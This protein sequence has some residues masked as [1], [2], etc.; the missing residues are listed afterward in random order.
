MWEIGLRFIFACSPGQIDDALEF[1]AHPSIL[2]RPCLGD[3]LSSFLKL[4]GRSLTMSTKSG[5]LLT[6]YPPTPSWHRFYDD[7]RKMITKLFSFWFS[8]QCS[9]T[10]LW[11]QQTR[12]GKNRGKTINHQTMPC[13][14]WLKYQ[15]NRSVSWRLS[16]TTYLPRLV[17]VVKERPPKSWAGVAG[18]ISKCEIT[19]KMQ[20]LHCWHRHG[21]RPKCSVHI[22]RGPWL[23]VGR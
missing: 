20:S 8:Y 15:N 12:T 16:C 10:I 2:D 23:G 18:W 13:K 17:N 11:S 5:P 9:R 1:F 3:S 7:L 14:W 6:T 19:L 22:F 21:L 4:R